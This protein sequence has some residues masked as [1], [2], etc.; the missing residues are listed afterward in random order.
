MSRSAA[1]R[2]HHHT[3]PA[4]RRRRLFAI[5]R[6]EFARHGFSRASLNR[7]LAEAGMSKSSFYHFF[8]D[9]SALFL[10][11]LEDVL[12]EVVGII[13]ALRPEAL[14]AESFWAEARAI[15]ERIAAMLLD[16]PD[17]AD[18]GRMF[19]RSLADSASCPF[20]GDE[21]A[22]PAARI[23]Q[24]VREWLATMIRRGQALGVV[25]TDLD[26]SLLTELVLAT[27]MA[28]DNWALARWEALPAADKERLPAI[29]LDLVMR[30]VTAGA[31]PPE[32]SIAPPGA[33]IA[34]AARCPVTGALPDEGTG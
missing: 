7:I 19:Y 12:G 24:G 15:T 17:L 20:I 25:R 27:G 1:A 6:Q 33:S 8:D 28:V 11:C 14:T 23:M 32:A 9:K 10:A 3:M 5:A 21:A 22:N 34:P 16:H 30:L 2:A 13:T 29:V 31:T 18:T 26:A 4:E